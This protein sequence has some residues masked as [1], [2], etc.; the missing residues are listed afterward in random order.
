VVATVV[1]PPVV[2]EEVHTLVHGDFQVD[3]VDQ[4]DMFL[5]GIKFCLMSEYFDCKIGYS[6]SI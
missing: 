2:E 5:P 1:V 6:Q 3:Q 4:E